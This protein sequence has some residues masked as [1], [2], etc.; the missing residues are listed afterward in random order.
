MFGHKGFGKK[1]KMCTRILI[2]HHL[3]T[4]KALHEIGI[5]AIIDT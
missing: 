5:F 3:C 4:Y 1:D 2:N